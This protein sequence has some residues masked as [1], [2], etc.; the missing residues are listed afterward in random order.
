M[1]LQPEPAAQKPVKPSPFG[2]RLWTFASLLSLGL[3]IIL[4]LALLALGRQ[5][6]VL[7]HILGDEVLGGLYTN[8]ILMDTASIKTNVAVQTDIHVAFNLPVK[9]NT[10]VTLTE[11]TP[12]TGALVTLT[13]GGLNISNAPANIILPA[14]TTLPIALDISVPVDTM[15]PVTLDVPVDI[16]LQQTE[17]HTPFIGLQEVVK[18]YYWLLQPQIKN[19]E[20]VAICRYS[21]GLCNLLFARP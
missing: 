3:N 1:T 19:P 13:T 10:T 7:K 21:L 4:L 6:F 20:D 12:I 9:T 5:V 2:P 16:P 14:G 18:P 8:F 11:N 15:V 17:L